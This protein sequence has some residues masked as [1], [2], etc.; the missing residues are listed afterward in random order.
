MAPPQMLPAGPLSTKGSQIVDQ[1]GNPVRIAS[2]GWFAFGNISQQ[3]S[4][5]KAAGFNC[6]RVEWFNRTLTNNLAT[7][8]KIVAACA[9]IGLRV[10]LDNHANEGLGQCVAQQAN[11]LWYD[12][13]GASNGTDGC[14]TA[15]TVSDAKFLQDW[16]T[17]AQHYKGNSTI[18]GYDLRNEPLAYNGM[19]TWE[20][21]NANPDHNIRYM[22]ERVGNAIHA[23][24][25]D[26][27]IICEGPQNYSQNFAKTG[28]APWGDLS[29]ANSL[30]VRLNVPNKVVYSVHDY[31]AE[32][33]GFATDSGSQKV[34]MM[35]KCWGYLVSQNIAP[36]WIGEMGSNMQS[37][38][39]KA[40]A[41]TLTDYMNGNL[42]AQG[43]P[44][45]TGNQQPISGDWWAWGNFDGEN[46]IGTLDST[47]KL[48]PEQQAVWSKI[49]FTS[50]AT[51]PTGPT[52][53]PA[54]KESLE[55]TKITKPTDPAIVDSIGELW[56]LNPSGKI[57]VGGAE[58]QTTAN[59]VLMVY[60]NHLVYQQ[61][62][63]GGWWYK[64]VASD[65]WVNT[66][67]PVIATPTGPTGPTAPTGPSG[68]TH[69]TVGTEIDQLN[70]LLTQAQTLISKIK[71]DV[72][73]LTP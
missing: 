49:L 28:P 4:Q 16:V 35:N 14:G 37:T 17:V 45:F 33:A 7:I 57:A 43:A 55:G 65:A 9:P 11:G 66:T 59:V 60:H 2:V 27:L 53:P 58:D 41:Q 24:D 42:G 39:S 54:P 21:G 72:A 15:G 23:V 22:Y 8:D 19:C 12:V 51:A 48:R 10:I 56:T 62:Q 50:T 69:V 5:I 46:P 36:V 70:S 25:T 38:G 61:N 47:G 1:N 34:Q 73:K 67:A 3:V 26:K 30:P 64:H 68:P 29:V 18:I 6:V 52:L 63:A 13:G 31:P 32:I 20:A 40:W 44:I 71:A